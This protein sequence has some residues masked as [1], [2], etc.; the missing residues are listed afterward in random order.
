MNVR[1]QIIFFS[2]FFFCAGGP[3]S[4]AVDGEKIFYNINPFG[5]SEYID[6][7]TVSL[8]GKELRAASFHTRIIGF[9]DAEKI[10]TDPVTGLP[11]RIERTIRWPFNRE[12]IVEEYDQEH[13]T[14]IMR[15]YKGKKLIEEHK[16]VHNGPIYSAIVFPFSLR[17]VPDPQIGWKTKTA[18]PNEFE[19]TLVSIDEVKVQAGH[20][21]AYHFTSAPHKFEIWIS[22]DKNL[23]PV[24][25]QGRGTFGGYTMKLHKYVPA[26]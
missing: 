14:L 16:S 20:F 24:K 7:G 11:V 26:P 2:I 5:K 13:F 22:R 17:H 23:I 9:D 21:T 8:E 25:I 12:F 10:Y 3:L 4:E 18:F 19:I 15:K 1:L 6:Q